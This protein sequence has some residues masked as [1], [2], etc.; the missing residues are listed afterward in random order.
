LAFRSGKK[1][2]FEEGGEGG[3][4]GSVNNFHP[5]F[6]GG[7]KGEKVGGVSCGRQQRPAYDWCSSPRIANHLESRGRESPAPMIRLLALR[8]RPCGVD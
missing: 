6:A 3:Q 2:R 4:R 1:K 7:K 5:Y 8:V